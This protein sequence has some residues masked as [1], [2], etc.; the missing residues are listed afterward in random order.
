MY[1]RLA[2]WCLL[3]A[4]CVVGPTISENRVSFAP[5][6]PAGCELQLVHTDITQ[7]EFNR[8]WDLLGYVTI[9]NNGVVDPAAPENREVVRPRACAM[10]G[11]AVS[12][13]MNTL[14][15][16][17]FGARGGGV[18]YMV[19]RPKAWAQGPTKF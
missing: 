18:V 2:P 11:T 19:L 8:R 9:V 10:G 3:F 6:R 17:T 5:A 14:S 4:A 7:V 12:V 1:V 15:Q 16:N 13:A